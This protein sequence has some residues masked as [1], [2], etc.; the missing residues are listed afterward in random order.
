MTLTQLRTFL[1]IAETGS[2][3]AAS[4]RLVV[5]QSAV[6]ASLAALQKSLGVPLIQREGRGLRLTDAGETY[7][8]YARRVLGLL[9]EARNA[10]VA[11]ANPEQGEL[12]IAALTTA[13]EQILPDLLTGFRRRHPHTGVVLEVGN[14]DRVRALLDRHD[15]DLVLG[16]R[17]MVGRELAV[18]A[19]RAHELIVVAAADLIAQVPRDQVRDWLARQTWLLREPGSG[20]RAATEGLLAGWDAEPR[21]LTVGSN[22]A[23]RESVM[24]GLGVSLISRDAVARELDAGRL[25]DVRIP[26]APMLRN[27]SLVA[28]PGRLPAT[29]ALFVEHVLDE[30]GFE[31][32]A[33]AD[34]DLNC[35]R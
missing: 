8:E 7:A 13:G 32:P 25:V 28:H 17:P 31:L 30:G 26:G 10:A 18:H 27:W 19:I 3:R 9:E 33:P 12:R 20:T 11:V 4:E 2:I 5:T 35:S 15:V 16:G 34:D 6:S 1:T 23:V 22:V 24:C 29:A 21:T 14:R